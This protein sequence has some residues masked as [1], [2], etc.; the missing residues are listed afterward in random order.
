MDCSCGDEQTI[1]TK[2]GLVDWDYLWNFLSIVAVLMSAG[3]FAD[4]LK[5]KERYKKER[6]AGFNEARNMAMDIIETTIHRVKMGTYDASDKDAPLSDAM[7]NIFEMMSD[8]DLEELDKA[9]KKLE[10][11]L[12]KH[13]EAKEGEF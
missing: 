1:T 8:Y 13:P 9:N 4:T 11:Y 7:I 12:K 2:G 3:L 6:Q 10:K 5:N